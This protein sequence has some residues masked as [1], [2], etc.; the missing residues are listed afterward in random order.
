MNCKRLFS[1]IRFIIVLKNCIYER[2]G[3]HMRQAVFIFLSIDW[4]SFG[5]IGE[6]K[7]EGEE[8]AIFNICREI[9]RERTAALLLLLLVF[10]KF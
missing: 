4:Q 3:S 7:G 9:S 5:K 1:F 8:K 6:W 2:S 10:K